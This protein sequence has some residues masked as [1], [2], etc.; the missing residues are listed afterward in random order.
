MHPFSYA[1]ADDPQAALAALTNGAEPIAGGTDMLQLL[2]DGVR[3]PDRIVDI[4]ALPLARVEVG[5]DGLLIGAL[6]RM[7]D[8]AE[9]PVVRERYPVIAEALLL[10]ASPQVRN[11]ATIGGNLM[12]R[13]RC[14]YFRDVAMPCNRRQP[15][16]G[17][18][19][20]H[21][22][23]RQHAIFG[24]GPNC[25]ATHPSDLA[26]ALVALDAVLRLDG[27]A[28]PRRVALADFHLIPG[29][30]PQRETV[31]APGEL[32]AAIEMPA[33][34][35]TRRS[36]YLKV[37]DRASFEFALCSAAVALDHDG[38]RIRSARVAA[39]GVGT[40]PWRLPRVEA[41]LAGAPLAAASLQ[42]AAALAPEGAQ[43]LEHNRFK[44]DLLQR[45]VLR[46][47]TTTGALA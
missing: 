45:T 43:P 46:A 38:A 13:T 36:R 27:P 26:V 16:S 10:S 20:R 40:K 22:E 7:S 25:V 23:N 34:P 47:L 12:Q 15:G 39:G 11:M 37:R 31:L 32:I 24:G 1:R 33:G 5:A 21:G 29:S 42:R 30:T 41:A 6:A 8:L 2:K 44:V 17:C 19:A 18:S 3:R 9:L 14:V 28:G 35:H 4:G